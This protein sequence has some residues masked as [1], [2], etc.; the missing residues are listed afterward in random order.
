MKI[1]CKPELATAELGSSSGLHSSSSSGKYS[2]ISPSLVTP[3]S[4][5]LVSLDGD[6]GLSASLVRGLVRGI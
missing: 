3:P 2:G 6:D 5:S 1:A 4:E